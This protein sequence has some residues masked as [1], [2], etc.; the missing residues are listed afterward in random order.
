MKYP[1]PSLRP[2]TKQVL[3]SFP[4]P[5]S[6][7]SAGMTMNHQVMVTGPFVPLGLLFWGATEDTYV[8]NVRVGNTFA[9][10]INHIEARIPARYF[11]TGRTFADLLALADAG[12]LQGAIEPRQVIQMAQADLGNMIGVQV[13]GPFESFCMWGLTGEGRL[14][15]LV[16]V[17]RQVKQ[18]PLRP[19]EP[20]LESWLGEVIERELAG[21][22]VAF[23]V[24]GPSPEVVSGLIAAFMARKH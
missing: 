24:E 3:L 10:D 20:P 12:E 15:L 9:V 21:D 1:Q 18:G 16:R 5:H 8:R 2:G 23:E 7:G 6:V 4:I 14:P 17:D 22:R 19:E 13:E 11:E